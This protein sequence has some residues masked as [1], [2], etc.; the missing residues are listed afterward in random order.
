MNTAL[1]TLSNLRIIAIDLSILLCIYWMPAITHFVPFPFYLIDPMRILLLA[2]YIISKDPFNTYFIALTIPI[3]SFLVA[4]HP[5]FVKASLISF[6]LFSNVFLLIFLI[7]RTKLK[8]PLILLFSIIASKGI[9]YVLK[10]TF[11]KIALIKGQIVT[12]DLQIQLFV[13]LIM[14]FAFSFFIKRK[15]TS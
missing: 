1:F 2:S 7:K 9:Y 5:I 4:G 13:V 12:T 15:S 11:I 10:Y 14:V 6:E 3:F 8:V